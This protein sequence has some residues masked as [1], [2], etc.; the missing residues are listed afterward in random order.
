MP[1]LPIPTRCGSALMVA[2]D[3]ASPAEIVWVYAAK[4][5]GDA[6]GGSVEEGVGRHC[7]GQG[8]RGSD[9]EALSRG[10]FMGGDKER[11]ARVGWRC[12]LSG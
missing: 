10:R 7:T 6:G 3:R 12:V 4:S 5:G 11:E 1:G 9:M 8:S 2:S